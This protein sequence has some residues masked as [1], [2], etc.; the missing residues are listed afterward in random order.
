MLD[1]R[2]TLADLRT[3]PSFPEL[4]ARPDALDPLLGLVRGAGARLVRV[5]AM[6]LVRAH[7]L[8]AFAARGVAALLD[9]LAHDDDEIRTFALTSFAEAPDLGRLPLADWLRLLDVVGAD[10][11]AIVVAQLVRHVRPARIDLPTR[12]AL[13]CHVAAPV[14]RLGLDLLEAEPPSD[15]DGVASL[16][17]L[18][19]ARCAVH[20]RNLAAFA[21]AHV[22]AEETYRLD[23]AMSFFDAPMRSVREGAF[24]WLSPETPAWNDGAL[25]SRLCETPYDDVRMRLVAALD[26]RT[27]LP[28]GDVRGD[29]RGAVRLWTT[30]LL[31]VHRGGRE[32]LRALRQVVD[33][34]A[35]RPDT[36]AELL[37][38]LRVAVRSSRGP[39]RR[40]GLSAVATLLARRPSLADDVARVLPE[41]VFAGD[42]A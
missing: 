27:R 7:H 31:A 12:V 15:A 26:Q 23:T 6:D 9:L 17:A 40:A 24:D 32:K 18:A 3:A 21:L 22:G 11:I 39:E 30:L 8:E 33:E 14:A 10:G 19:H 38:A 36:A 35:R 37:P 13:A 34:I 16:A 2:A 20:G 5:A 29:V 25:W 4:W 28:G 41:L 1:P 42:A